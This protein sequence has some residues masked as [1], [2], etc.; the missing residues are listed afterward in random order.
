MFQLEEVDLKLAGLTPLHWLDALDESGPR[1][2]I[3]CCMTFSQSVYSARQATNERN[4]RIP[5]W[6]V[7]I[8]LRRRGRFLGGRTGRIKLLVQR[9]L[10]SVHILIFYP[11]FRAIPNLIK[12]TY[13]AYLE[14]YALVIIIADGVRS[15]FHISTS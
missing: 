1:G 9:E 8:C 2:N 14:E 15:I 6:K 4:V 12:V 3:N 11:A 13:C 10:L 7:V 5:E